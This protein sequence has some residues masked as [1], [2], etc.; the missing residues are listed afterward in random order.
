MPAT[1]EPP[2]SSPF[3]L[4]LDMSQN[5]GDPD[6]EFF[7]TN[8]PF[9]ATSSPS[10]F[11]AEEYNVES[12]KYSATIDTTV[13]AALKQD[14]R[15][16]SSFPDSRPKTLSAPSSASPA[17]SF[18]DDSSDSS[19][20]KR[21]SSSDSSRSALTGGDFMMADADMN[22]WKADEMMTGGE[23]VQFAGYDGTINPSSMNNAFGFSDQAMENDFDFDSAA[24]SPFGPG[25]VDMES[26]E[27]PTIKYDTPRRHCP[28]MRT[29]PGHH[30]K[31]NSVRTCS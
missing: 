22:D 23:G 30:A 9:A 26:P 19:R 3:I 27:M 17:G 12:P 15:S 18:Q 13:P 6:F 1:E 2:Y 24:S 28:K 21:K 14:L 11:L 20:Y 25:A 5:L 10:A 4:D 31:M 8:T 29:K 16:Q 7:D